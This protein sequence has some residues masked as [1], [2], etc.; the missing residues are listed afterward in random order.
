VHPSLSLIT[1]ILFP[2]ALTFG[3]KF[4][5]LFLT[6]LSI[7]WDR[8]IIYSQMH[9]TRR[10]SAH[11]LRLIVPRNMVLPLRNMVLPLRNMVLPHSLCDR[12]S[13]LTRVPM[14]SHVWATCLRPSALSHRSLWQSRHFL[15]SV[16]YRSFRPIPNFRP[17]IASI[18]LLSSPAHTYIARSEFP[19][20]TAAGISY[21]T[22]ISFSLSLSLS[23]SLPFRVV[24]FFRLRLS[25]QRD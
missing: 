22:G 13:N 11:T 6:R 19:V 21:C 17:T 23:I 25:A 1:T 20:A 3:K 12:P 10:S 2:R 5:F 9:C 8:I 14:S 15:F 18:S 4:L 16:C 7:R 24:V